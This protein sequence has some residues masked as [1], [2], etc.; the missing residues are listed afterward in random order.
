MVTEGRVP[1]LLVECK[2]SDGPV[3]KGLRYLS[4]R[5]PDCEA[6]QVYASGRKDYETAEGIRVGHALELLRGLI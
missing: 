4:Q 5:F 6:H 2:W 3:D 1:M